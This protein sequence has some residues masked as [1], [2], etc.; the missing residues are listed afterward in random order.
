M[1]EQPTSDQ[2]FQRLDNLKRDIESIKR[3]APKFSHIAAVLSDP[4]HGALGETV[5]GYGEHRADPEIPDLRA[6]SE[7]ILAAQKEHFDLSFNQSRN[8]QGTLKDT[9][10]AEL[11]KLK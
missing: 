5:S 6:L 10:A 7:R 9:F 2:L 1:S 8:L 11:Q 4:L 3:E